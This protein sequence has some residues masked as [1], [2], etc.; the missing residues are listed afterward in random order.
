[1]LQGYLDNVTQLGEDF[2][3]ST[4]AI[5]VPPKAPLGATSSLKDD[6]VSSKE[7]GIQYV[8][9]LGALG[10]YVAQVQGRL[11]EIHKDLAMAR[12]EQ[13]ELYDACQQVSE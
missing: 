5:P 13:E 8:E 2:G 7:A 4:S 11:G 6:V 12:G 10:G 9:H 1:M 3:T